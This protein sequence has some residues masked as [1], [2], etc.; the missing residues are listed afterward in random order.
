MADLANSKIKPI[1]KEVKKNRNIGKKL[2]SCSVKAN[3]NRLKNTSR[4]VLLL[5]KK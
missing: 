4:D 3:I 1:L 2:K 5:I